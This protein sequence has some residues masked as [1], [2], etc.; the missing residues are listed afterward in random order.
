MLM[1]IYTIFE[2]R[3]FSTDILKAYLQKAEDLNK[4]YFIMHYK[5]FHLDQ[6]NIIKLLKLLYQLF[7]CGHLCDRMFQKHLIKI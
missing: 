4:G 5:E 7:K 1:S 3:S 6:E 2:F